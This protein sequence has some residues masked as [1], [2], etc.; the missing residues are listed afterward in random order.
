MAKKKTPFG[1][2]AALSADPDAGQWFIARTKPRCEFRAIEGLAEIG[3]TAYAPAETRF[4]GRGAARKAVQYPL[5]ASYVF[6]ILTPQDSF[7]NVRRIDGVSSILLGGD[8]SPEAVSHREVSRFARK[9]IDGKFDH[10]RNAPEAKKETQRI[11]M[12]LG[13]LQALGRKTAT[14]MVMAIL[15]GVPDQMDEA[16]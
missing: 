8:G 12:N 1:P 11:K 6:F 9:E 3:V 16:A 15:D 4:R 7:Y 10:T 13:D 5:L 14:D 2:D